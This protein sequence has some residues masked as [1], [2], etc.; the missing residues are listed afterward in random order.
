MQVSANLDLFLI[1]NKDLESDHFYT[2]EKIAL[3]R[4]IWNLELSSSTLVGKINRVTVL[5][6]WTEEL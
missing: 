1:R 2:K 4:E 5:H 3:R 6:G